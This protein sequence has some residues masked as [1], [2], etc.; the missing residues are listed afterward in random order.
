MNGW[1]A[2]PFLDGIPNA[3]SVSA[4][5]E[6]VVNG[7]KSLVAKGVSVAILLVSDPPSKSYFARG[8]KQRT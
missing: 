1:D 8:A 5:Y 2:N 3:S 4:P 6:E 7:L